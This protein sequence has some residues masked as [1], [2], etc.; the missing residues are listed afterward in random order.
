LKHYVRAA[1][2]STPIIWAVGSTSAADL[3]LRPFASAA[4]AHEVSHRVGISI[5]GIN[6][7]ARLAMATHRRC[8]TGVFT[9]FFCLRN[10]APQTAAP[11]E[12][13]RRD[14]AADA[15]DTCW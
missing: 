9:N 12:L 8:E 13:A 7:S 10:G 15:P 2:A 3:P 6:S 4:A 5:V 14:S 11:V 1:V